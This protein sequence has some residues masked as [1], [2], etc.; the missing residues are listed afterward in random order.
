MEISF[1]VKSPWIST[2]DRL[3]PVG[4]IVLVY[5]EWDDAYSLGCLTSQEE[6]LWCIAEDFFN[7]LLVDYWKEL[8]DLMTPPTVN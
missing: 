4:K 7:F 5:S 3:P 6:K 8:D 1:K 2:K